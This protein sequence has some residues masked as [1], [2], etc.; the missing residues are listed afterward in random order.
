MDALNS[1]TKAERYIEFLKGTDEIDL[2]IQRLWQEF[3]NRNLPIRPDDLSIKRVLDL[4]SGPGNISRELRR[5]FLGHDIRCIERTPIYK[6]IYDYEVVP[7]EDSEDRPY[8]FILLSHV[9]QYID[10]D[11]E[12]FLMKVIESLTADGE[13]WIIQQTQQGMY[14][15]IMHVREHLTSQRFK[16]WQTFEDYIEIVDRLSKRKGCIYTIEYL[17]SSFAGFQWHSLSQSDILRLEFILCIN[18]LTQYLKQEP[19]MFSGLETMGRIQHPNGILRI[20]RS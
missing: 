5:I 10:T 14:E 4:G 9:L 7:F 1:F 8:D 13:V 6:D 18:D 15:V 2:L 11:V 20:R 19:L 3:L 12:S 17:P 16:T